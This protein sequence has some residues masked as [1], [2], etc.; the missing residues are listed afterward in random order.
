MKI[1]IYDKPT[2]ELNSIIPPFLK[3]NFDGIDWNDSE[4]MEEMAEW[5]WNPAQIHLLA[6]E[7]DELVGVA[8][9]TKRTTTFENKQI[10]IACFGGLTVSKKHRGKGIATKLI[11]KCFEIACEWNADIAFL[12]TAIR[13]CKFYMRFGFVRMKNK[14]SFKG[15][16]GQKHKDTNG[17]IA[18]LNFP[19]K[20]KLVLE[21]KE[22]LYIDEG[23]L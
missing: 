23:N 17:M 19:E 5:Y 10:I 12:N 6:Y 3:E 18:P 14:Y 9:L 13:N 20:F 11:Q 7:G 1:K 4:T 22:I 2:P 16:S 21:S 8:H 15:K